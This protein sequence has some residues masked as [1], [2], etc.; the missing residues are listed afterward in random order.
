MPLGSKDDKSD[1]AVFSIY[2]LSVVANR[3]AWTYNFSRPHLEANMSSMIETCNWETARYAQAC[4]GLSKDLRA[5]V[6]VIVDADPKR[7]SRPR[8]ECPGP[9]FGDHLFARPGPTESKHPLRP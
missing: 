1:R 9:G 2:S 7:I 4:E 6:E 8:R 5:E 3:D